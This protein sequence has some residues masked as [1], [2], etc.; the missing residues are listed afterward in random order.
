M[1]CAQEKQKAESLPKQTEYF[2]KTTDK[3]EKI[4]KKDTRQ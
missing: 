2:Q 3:Q 1:S 4:T